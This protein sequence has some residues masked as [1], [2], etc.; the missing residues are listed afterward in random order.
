MRSLAAL[1]EPV[2]DDDGPAGLAELADED[3]EV[4]EDAA[5]AEEEDA[6]AAPVL[7][8]IALEGFDVD[9]EV[10]GPEDAELADW[11]ELRVE[12]AVAEVPDLAASD[13]FAEAEPAAVSEDFAATDLASRSIVTGRLPGFAADADDVEEEPGVGPAEEAPPLDEPDAP[14]LSLPPEACGL[15]EGS[16]SV[17]IPIRPHH[18]PFN[19][20][21][22]LLLYT[23]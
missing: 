4:S 9:P 7:G 19:T 2:A 13:D 10:D 21:A 15:L 5:P 22:L 16:L 20:G 6:S 12:E 14:P 1:S 17:A 8:G 11:E 3:L 18:F 23:P